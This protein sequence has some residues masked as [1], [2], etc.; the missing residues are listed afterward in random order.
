MK[1]FCRQNNELYSCV[2]ETIWRSQELKLNFEPAQ[3]FEYVTKADFRKCYAKWFSNLDDDDRKTVLDNI[4]VI[5]DE[6]IRMGNYMLDETWAN[7]VY[8]LSAMISDVKLDRPTSTA[9]R[10]FLQAMLSQKGQFLFLTDSTREQL[11][12]ALHQSANDN[13]QKSLD[14]I[15]LGFTN[16]LREGAVQLGETE[17][18]TIQT[19]RTAIRQE[20]WLQM[21]PDA[22]LFPEKIGYYVRQQRYTVIGWRYDSVQKIQPFIANLQDCSALQLPEKV[23]SGLPERQDIPPLDELYEALLIDE[24][25]V[26][27]I[28]HH[29]PDILERSF[30][31]FNQYQ[32]E[33]TIKNEDVHIFRVRCFR[34]EEEQLLRDILS[35]GAGVEVV[36]PV[37]MREQVRETWRA[38]LQQYEQA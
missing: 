9:E 13:V 32:K 3:S 14:E 38:M 18:A 6:I 11:Q 1:L 31:L 15:D 23:P 19:I 17:L 24:P 10:Y 16:Y 36:S 30:A 7:I 20:K 25:V 27:K 26:I 33:G 28:Q 21:G 29:R 37:A 34:F 2:Q 8:I 5:S 12:E 22:F 35:L 4:N